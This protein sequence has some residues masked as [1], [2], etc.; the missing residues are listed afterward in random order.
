MNTNDW[1]RTHTSFRH[2]PGSNVC[3]RS[4]N[5]GNYTT[6]CEFVA[7]DDNTWCTHSRELYLD[8]ATWRHTTKPK[9]I[10]PLMLRCAW[11]N[12]EVD[13]PATWLHTDDYQM[14][15]QT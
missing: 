2:S 14:K 7:Y 8:R 10:G 1:C 13:P 4:V 5:T 3:D 11:C 12:T 9:R 6:G 15:L